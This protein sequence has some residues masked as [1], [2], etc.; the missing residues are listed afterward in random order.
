MR[1]GV[2]R[3]RV[4][5]FYGDQTAENVNNVYDTDTVTANYAPFRFRRFRSGKF[6]VKDELFSGEPIIENIDK[7]VEDRCMG[8]ARVFDCGLLVN[9]N[10]IDSL[11]NSRGR[12]EGSESSMR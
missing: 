12:E 11:V 8:A 10:N 7:I 2:L 4:F 6:D 9:S 3:V 1:E 5:F